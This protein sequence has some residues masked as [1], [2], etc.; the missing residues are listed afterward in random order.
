MR[1]SVVTESILAREEVYLIGPDNDGAINLKK[2]NR[3]KKFSGEDFIVNLIGP[4][5]ISFT[6]TYEMMA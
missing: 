6:I 5:H 1:Y 2:L 3:A 4:I